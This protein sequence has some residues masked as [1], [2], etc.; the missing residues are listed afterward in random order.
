[1]KS[2][3]GFTAATLGTMRKLLSA[4]CTGVRSYG[5]VMA[6]TLLPT[7]AHANTYLF[8]VTASSL[9]SALT[10]SDSDESTSAYFAV[11]LQ[12]SSLSQSYSYGAITAPSTPLPAE[13]WDTGTITDFSLGSGT[14]V[15]FS[16][17]QSQTTVA[18]L[19]GETATN[20]AFDFQ[21][22]P[23]NDNLTWPLGWGT[24]S[25]T[26]Q[27][28]LPNTDTF[29]FLVTTNQNLGSTAT[30][31]G[32]AFSVWDNAGTYKTNIDIPITVT[33]TV[34]SQSPEPETWGLL[35]SGVLLLTLGQ[36]I[37]SR[38]RRRS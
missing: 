25:G 11:M 24:V 28:Q 36:R 34:T 32:K 31:T 18:V 33:A 3:S 8:S 23:Y 20:F 4:C 15:R 5:V 27:D 35:G 7:V 9:I 10:I 19:S 6:L 26:I 30:V 21:G 37:K 2:M 29:K 16:K 17:A 12:P 22:T 1:M 38:R 14:F 13:T